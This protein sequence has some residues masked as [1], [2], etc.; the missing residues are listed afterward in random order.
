M[1]SSTLIIPEYQGLTI[2]GNVL[3]R[4]ELGEVCHTVVIHTTHRGEVEV[5]FWLK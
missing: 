3:D 2:A 4:D 1:T 5:V